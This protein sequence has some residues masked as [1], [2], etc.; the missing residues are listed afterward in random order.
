MK[1]SRKKRDSEPVSLHFHSKNYVRRRK[2][3]IESQ[4]RGITKDLVDAAE[5]VHKKGLAV[6]VSSTRK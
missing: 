1:R 4:V 3:G 2:G 5:V 6:W